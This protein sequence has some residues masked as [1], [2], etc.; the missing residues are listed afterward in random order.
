M[1]PM[2]EP[3]EELDPGGEARVW[4]RGFRCFV[5]TSC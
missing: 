4:S 2:S 5:I 3:E 1:V